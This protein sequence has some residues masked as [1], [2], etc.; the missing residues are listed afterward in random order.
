MGLVV[1]GRELG[2]YGHKGFPGVQGSK[3]LEGLEGV[4]FQSSLTDRTAA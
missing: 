1:R 3:G 2:G 4:S